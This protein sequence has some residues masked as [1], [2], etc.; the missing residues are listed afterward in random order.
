LDIAV[1]EWVIKTALEQLEIWREH[2]I[3]LPVS[4]NLSGHHLQQPGFT[5]RLAG[6]LAAHPSIPPAHLELEVLES[7]ALADMNMIARVIESCAELG[8]TF[9]LDDFGTGYSSLTYLK[10]LPART[11][12]IDR[13]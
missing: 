13:S 11:I 7:S 2:G 4:I 5:N 6:I 1:G 12:K 10:R 9:A 8:V 3:E